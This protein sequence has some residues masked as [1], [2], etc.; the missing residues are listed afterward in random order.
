M[1]FQTAGGNAFP[2]HVLV[3]LVLLLVDYQRNPALGISSSTCVGTLFACSPFSNGTDGGT[4]TPL[5]L[6][7]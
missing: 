1:D 5:Q 6:T 7:V 2:P 3:E 4:P